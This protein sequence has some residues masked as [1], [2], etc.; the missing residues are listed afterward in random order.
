MPW[1]LVFL[2]F[3]GLVMDLDSIEGLNEIRPFVY[4]VAM[5]L[6]S[7]QRLSHMDV[8]S[9]RHITAA[10]H[11]GGGAKLQQEVGLNR[12]EVTRTLNRMFHSVSQ[13]APVH[14]TEGAAEEMCRLVFR[15]HD[16]SALLSQD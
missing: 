14:V 16:R 4:R 7:L 1:F 3:R 5:K 15:L 11:S 13:E 10:L 2:C 8:V 12:Q 6:L 9:F